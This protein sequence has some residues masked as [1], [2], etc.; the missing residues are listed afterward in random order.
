VEEV[1]RV[2]RGWAGYFHYGNSVTVMKRMNRYSQNRFRRWLWRKHAC[3][4]GLWTHYQTEQ[5]HARY[6]LY[7]LHQIL[8]I[9]R[10]PII[11]SQVEG[12]GCCPILAL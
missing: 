8:Q 11:S 10:C 5:L 12:F 6:G 9:G 1:N 3:R 4:R 2:L 7:E